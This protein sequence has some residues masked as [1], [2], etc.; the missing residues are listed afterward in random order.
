[1]AIANLAN[2]FY[3]FV[4]MSP[5]TPSVPP[6]VAPKKTRWLL[7]GCGTLLAVLLVIVATVAITLWW[8]Q[9]P[10]KPV[11]LSAREK[12]TVDEKL[13]H[14]SG[15]PTL[16]PRAPTPDAR[17]YVPGSKV[18]KLTDHEING[19]L[20]ANTDLGKSVRLEFARDAINAYVV[21]PI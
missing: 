10:I 16:T 19:L 4:T 2:Q 12:A 18:L 6:P 5:D 17:S 21:V 13:Q 3:L 1:M 15:T 8:I 20:N 11:V 7:Y 9:R 14:V